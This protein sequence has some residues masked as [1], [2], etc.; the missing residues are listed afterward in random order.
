MRVVLTSLRLR[1]IRTRAARRLYRT[2]VRRFTAE[3]VTHAPARIRLHAMT[4]FSEAGTRGPVDVL[5][6]ESRHRDARCV[7]TQL[8]SGVF[9]LRFYFANVDSKYVDERR[10]QR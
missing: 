6:Q 2:E 10:K 1:S 8:R 9:V 7:Q 3:R 5:T 4:I